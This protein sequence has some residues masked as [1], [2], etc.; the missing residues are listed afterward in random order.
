MLVELKSWKAL[1]PSNGW[2]LQT[3]GGPATLF[4]P[5]IAEFDF[6]HAQ[7]GLRAAAGWPRILWMRMLATNGDQRQGSSVDVLNSDRDLGSREMD[8]ELF[9]HVILPFRPPPHS[10]LNCTS[11]RQ[12]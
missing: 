2:E 11:K 3:R 4:R 5:G 7:V 8:Q 1:R 6:G 10:S 9:P 12:T